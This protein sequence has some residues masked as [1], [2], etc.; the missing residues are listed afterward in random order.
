MDSIIEFVIQNAHHAH[1]FIFGSI[2]LAGMNLPISTDVLIIVSAVLAATVVPENTLQLFLGVFFGCTFSAWLAY[3]IGRAI[4]PKLCNIRW[5]SKL[6]NA[7]RLEKVKNFYEKHGFLTLLIGR[8]IPFGI[9]NCI[10]M[11][12]GMSKMHFGK[13]VLRDLVACFTWSAVSFYVF[14]A[15]GQNWE[16]L[17]EYVKTFNILIFLAFLV[18]VIGVIW[19]KRRKRIRSEK[20]SE[21]PK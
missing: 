13:F 2:I 6:L 14:Y 18:T 12:T 19:Y 11:T 7:K 15:M 4:G 21:T 1:W 17:Y 20:A 3:W 8:F 10:F 9:R 16:T 5:F